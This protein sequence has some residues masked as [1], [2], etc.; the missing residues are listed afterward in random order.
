MERLKFKKGWKGGIALTRHWKK[1]KSEKGKRERKRK[2]KGYISINGGLGTLGSTVVDQRR[3]KG[4]GGIPNG[5]W[6]KELTQWDWSGGDEG[7][8]EHVQINVT[9]NR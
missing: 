2:I 5:C 4:G 6:G 1:H 9:T 3:K 7:E 8:R